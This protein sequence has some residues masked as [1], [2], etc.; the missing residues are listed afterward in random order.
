M[1]R[2]RL[3]SAVLSL[4]KYFLHTNCN[5]TPSISL[6]MTFSH[7]SCMGRFAE[8]PFPWPLP[9][10]TPGL[11]LAQATHTPAAEDCNFTFHRGGEGQ[12]QPGQGPYTT[13]MTTKDEPDKEQLWK[14]HYYSQEPFACIN[15]D[16]YRIRRL[17]H[18][19]GRIN[20]NYF[21][22]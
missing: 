14:P 3:W 9:L 10:H 5:F 20:G 1:K 4:T 11:A 15:L 13:I 2:E 21:F 6:T 8:A 18:D 7:G 22:I 17:Q 12:W 16:M 19:K